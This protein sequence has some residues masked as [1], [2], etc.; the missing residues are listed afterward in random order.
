M[1][2]L[3]HIEGNNHTKMLKKFH[4]LSIASLYTILVFLVKIFGQELKFTLGVVHKRRHTNFLVFWHPLHP[5][6]ISSFLGA[7]FHRTTSFL[8]YLPTSTFIP[9]HTFIKDLR[10]F[11][12][13]ETLG[14]PF[15]PTLLSSDS[16]GFFPTQAKAI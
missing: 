1:F 4:E 6:R 13:L 10:V 3:Y 7:P 15:Y 14:G 5:N 11:W 16:M 2:K 12:V 9:D 8:R